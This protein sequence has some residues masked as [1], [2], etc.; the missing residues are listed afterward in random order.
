M[1][2]VLALESSRRCHL[3]HISRILPVTASSGG[4]E[5]KP[6]DAEQSGTLVA[7]AF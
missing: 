2:V 6:V 1:I 3:C 5:S 7:D 4:G